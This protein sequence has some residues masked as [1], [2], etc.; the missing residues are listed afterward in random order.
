MYQYIVGRNN[1]NLASLLPR[2]LYTGTLFADQR[3]DKNFDKNNLQVNQSTFANCSFKESKIKSSDF[4]HCVF[5]DCYFRK[6]Q[7]EGVMLTGCKFINCTFDEAIFVQCDV[8]YTTFEGCYIEF[9]ALEGSLPS[10]SNIR[11]KICTNLALE[12]LR[13]GNSEQYRKYFFEEKRSSESHYKKM[14]MQSNPYY[15]KKY[16]FI[17]RIK[18]LFLLTKSKTSKYVWGYGERISHLVSVIILVILAFTICYWL[19]N[20]VFKEANNSNNNVTRDLSFLESLY[21]SFCNFLTLTSDFT[22]AS[23]M[24]RTITVVEGAL[25]VILMGFFVAAL[26]RYI[27][28]R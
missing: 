25:G 12:S 14:I 4:A 9:E 26:F 3:P 2:Q 27:N 19:Q 18:G 23:T 1:E 20:G 21:L 6:T 24:V 28:R 11:W 7:F 15:K 17:D 13:Q 8:R 16:D 10:T 5:I 22:T